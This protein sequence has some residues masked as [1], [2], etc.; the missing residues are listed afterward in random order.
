MQPP[1]CSSLCHPASCTLP[2]H[3]TKYLCGSTCVSLTCASTSASTFCYLD[4]RLHHLLCHSPA[5]LSLGQ[6]KK[7]NLKPFPCLRVRFRVQNTNPQTVTHVLCSSR[8]RGS[9]R[10]HGKRT[11]RLI[12]L[13]SNQRGSCVIAVTP[14]LQYGHPCCTTC[15]GNF[16]ATWRDLYF[17]PLLQRSVMLLQLTRGSNLSIRHEAYIEAVYIQ[18]NVYY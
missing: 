18:K 10:G 16:R 13:G 14:Y 3:Q 4:P 1:S 5:T 8:E 11:L 15:P 9:R 6:T 12:Q 17:Y 7:F 2:C